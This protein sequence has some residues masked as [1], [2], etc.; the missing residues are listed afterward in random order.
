M[1]KKFHVW[2]LIAAIWLGAPIDVVAQQRQAPAFEHVHALALDSNGQ[3]LFLGAH[4]GVFRSDDGGR[5]WKKVP[6]S[7]THSHIDVMAVTPDPREPKT[8]YVATHEAGVFKS[9]DGGLSWKQANHGLG[10]MDVHGL[11]VDPNAPAT[12]YAAI[13]EKGDGVYRTT[14]GGEKWTRVDDGPEGEVKILKS[15]NIS[16]GMG[17]IFLYAGTSTGLQRSPDCF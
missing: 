14:D 17:G 16:T 12:L 10:G 5:S 13:R 2:L 15:V 9:T 11:A 4:T 8:I 3:T 7:T 1:Q 6:L